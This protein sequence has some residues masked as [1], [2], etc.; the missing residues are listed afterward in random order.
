MYEAYKELIFVEDGE[1][2][3]NI[4]YR[5]KKIFDFFNNYLNQDAEEIPG[6]EKVVLLA[7]TNEIIEN[8]ESYVYFDNIT[9]Q[10]KDFIKAR[11][12]GVIIRKEKDQETGK[13]ICILKNI[14]NQ[15]VTSD[16]II[17]ILYPYFDKILND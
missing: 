5:N 1:K 3:E 10:E 4:E 2:A 12:R 17:D 15:K 7:D 14:A 16:S 8:G 13:E 9:S 6:L 11:K